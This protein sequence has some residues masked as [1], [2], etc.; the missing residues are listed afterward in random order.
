MHPHLYAFAAILCW[1]SLPAATG[2]CLDGL[3]VTE[4]LFFS[5]VP[6]ALYLA[7]QEIVLRRSLRIPIPSFNLSLLGV[8][9]IFGY[10]WVYY[11][12]LDHAPVVEGAILA[13][14]WSFW[15]VI[16][17]SVLRCGMLRLTT[18]GLA[19]L[20]MYGAYLVIAGGRG[21]SFDAAY[22]EGYI[23]ALGCGF[24]WSGFSV[25]LSRCHPAEDYMPAF[26][27][28]AALI[29][30]G[31]FIVHVYGT[32]D[33]A[34]PPVSV[35]LSALYLGL[36]PLGLSFTLWNKAVVH[37]NMTIVGYLSYLTPPLAVLLVAV[38]RQAPVPVHAVAGL[39]CILAAAMLG[40]LQLRE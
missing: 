8:I 28:F 2:N 14:T 31:M 10:H 12:A 40:R 21:L 19:V 37:G 35:L 39:V 7:G 24:I 3:S 20:G 32:T 9:G 34:L 30:S 38:V 23:Y 26:T 17:S 16:I 6:A 13:T 11:L 1:A 22:L 18:L 5:F 15:I 27:I 4:L 29:S 36:V 33:Y 25:T